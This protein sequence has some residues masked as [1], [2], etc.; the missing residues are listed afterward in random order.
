MGKKIYL[1]KIIRKI[2]KFVYK[3]KEKYLDSNIQNTYE[4]AQES[5][6]KV[7]DIIKNELMLDK[8]SLITRFGST[9][10]LSMMDYLHRGTFKNA[11]KF[12][13]SEIEY[14]GWR[15]ST[16][17]QMWNCSGF[18]PPTEKN[19]EKYSELLYNLMPE[20]DVLGTWLKQEQYFSKELKN[21]TRVPL[22]DLE[23]FYYENP[24]TVA[25]E[26]KNVLIIHPFE[27]TILHQYKNHKLLFEN[28]KMLPDFNLLTIR[29]VQS[30]AKN[31]DKF[32]SW[33]DAF[34]YMKSE[35]DKKDFD[36][37]IIA[38]GT[39]GMPLAAY[40]KKIGKKA[41]HLGGSLQLMFGIKGRRWEEVETCANSDFYMKLYND[42]W[43]RPFDVDTPKS[44]QNVE[45]GCYW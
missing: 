42:Y 17:D 32:N 11:I 19:L 10:M 21:A 5:G 8:P 34:E 31:N 6:Q 43:I 38:C 40:V 24:W 27:T 20:I 14:L 28:K 44:F 30:I 16:Q 7:S 41:I 9:E 22:Y 4:W 1:L 36:I 2:L 33:F 13:M 23:P 18:F 15:K 26:G 39:Y 29:A 25:L 12:V 3:P 37:A 35:I 45:N